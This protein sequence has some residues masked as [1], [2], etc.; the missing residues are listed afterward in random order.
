[1]P[2]L[3]SYLLSRKTHPLFK[4]ELL[5]LAVGT[6]VED[7]FLISFQSE[8]PNGTADFLPVSIP[9][10]KMLETWV[11][12]TDHFPVRSRRAQSAPL[13]GGR[14]FK[15]QPCVFLLVESLR[16]R[17]DIYTAVIKSLVYSALPTKKFQQRDF[18]CHIF[19]SNNI[20]LFALGRQKKRLYH[21]KW[22]FKLSMQCF[23]WKYEVIVR[24]SK[25][26]WFFEETVDSF[27]CFEVCF[28]IR[29]IVFLVIIFKKKI[30][31]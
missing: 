31:I 14:K 11:C 19:C 16:A 18:V 12:S 20:D 17:R 21:E 13:S 5:C 4:G 23:A 28:H 22:Q 24:D 2:T 8:R 7:E 25:S 27:K 1:L 6:P 10:V 9:A 29:W 15:V 26:S 30:A 3:L